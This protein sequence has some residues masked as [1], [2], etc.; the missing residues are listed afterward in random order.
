MMPLGIGTL[1]DY[2]RNRERLDLEKAT[3]RL[4]VPYLIVHGTEDESVSIGDGE[5]L[6][7]AA[8]AA[9]S[10]FA[11][12]EGAGHTFGAVHPFRGTTDH[13]ERA[14]EL[15]ADWFTEHLPGHR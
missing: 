8:P 5:Q 6:A 3:G 11:P 4:E 14:I 12:I 15:S 7:E 9:T 1:E 13:L 2:E 10:R